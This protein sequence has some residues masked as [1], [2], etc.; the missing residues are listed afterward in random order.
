MTKTR[1][2]VNLRITVNSLQYLLAFCTTILLK[3]IGFTTIE[4]L[5]AITVSSRKFIC[6]KYC[7]IRTGHCYS[8]GNC[9]S[10]HAIVVS[11]ILVKLAASSGVYDYAI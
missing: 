9:I 3:N 1:P 4:S 10:A 2:E 5:L 6:P 8:Y 11:S 7:I